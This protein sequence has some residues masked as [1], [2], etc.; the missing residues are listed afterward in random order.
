MDSCRRLR[1]VRS[2]SQSLASHGPRAFGPAVTCIRCSSRRLVER[3]ALPSDGCVSL[4]APAADSL[5][6]S[7]LSY[8]RQGR[9]RSQALASHPSLS[10]GPAVPSNRC[11]SRRLEGWRAQ[12]T[13]DARKRFRSSLEC[14][15]ADEL[16]IILVC[17]LVEPSRTCTLERM[18]W[19]KVPGRYRNSTS[20]SRAEV[21][22]R[23]RLVR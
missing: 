16:F 4:E 17:V 9:S 6:V 14:A 8:L 21:I 7:C 2:C 10:F 11:S 1:Q 20:K 22:S 19:H 18:M 3:K 15:C 5:L 23:Y 13:R 12:R